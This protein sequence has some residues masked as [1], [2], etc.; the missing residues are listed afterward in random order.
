MNFRIISKILSYNLLVLAFS[1]SGCLLFAVFQ[2]S[3]KPENLTA[4]F[5]CILYSLI[6]S[7]SLQLLGRRAK[8][9]ILRKEALAIVGLSWLVCSVVGAVPYH[10]IAGTGPMDSFFESA[11]GFTTTGASIFSEIELLP[12]D[13]LLWRCLT[14]WIGGLGMISMFVFILSIEGGGSKFLFKGES[15]L[16]MRDLGS[17][18]VQ[19]GI[20]NITITYLVLSMACA[21]CFYFCGMDLYDSICHSFATVSTG[22]FSTHSA[23]IGYFNSAPIEWTCVVFMLLGGTNFVALINLTMYRRSF[24]SPE[25]IFYYA[26]FFTITA[27]ILFTMQSFCKESV[28]LS[29]GFRESAF[30]VASLLTSTG[31]ASTDYEKWIPAEHMFLLAAMIMGGCTGSTAGGLKSIRVLVAFRICLANIERVF[32]P[33]IRRSLT[34]FG[35]TLSEQ[36]RDDTLHYVFLITALCFAAMP[37]LSL[38]E[39]L[40]SEEGVKSAVLACLFNVGPGFAEVG[41]TDNYGFLKDTSKLYLSMLMIMGRVEIYAI[42]VFFIPSFWKKS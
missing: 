22:G 32:R 15:S 10:M 14:Q 31:F 17:S 34:I 35:K 3:I 39:P 28:S 25:T 40:M 19:V 1:F 36:E 37:I 5:Y 8:P 18:N 13:L 20:R 38:M 9:T 4:W 7:V 11:S 16:Q 2:Q 23:S 26:T 33:N 6:G 30:Q 21:S 42:I 27:L 29:Q 41:A 24:L 12:M